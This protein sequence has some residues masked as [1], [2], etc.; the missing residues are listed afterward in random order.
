MKDREGSAT[1]DLETSVVAKQCKTEEMKGDGEESEVESGEGTRRRERS[2]TE[3]NGG[4]EGESGKKGVPQYEAANV[5]DCGGHKDVMVEVYLA[6]WVHKGERNERC[7][8]WP[9]TG[10]EMSTEEI[11]ADGK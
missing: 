7:A 3:D 9:R 10:R 4:Q 8:M 11:N 6:E 1:P 2:F 5:K